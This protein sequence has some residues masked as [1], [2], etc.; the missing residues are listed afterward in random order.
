MLEMKTMR[1]IT[2]KTVAVRWL[3]APAAALMLVACD[4]QPT[5]EQ[6]AKVAKEA[7][8]IQAKAQEAQLTDRWNTLSAEIPQIVDVVTARVEL[9]EKKHEFPEGV[10]AREVK[11]AASTMTE[12]WQQALGAFANSNM[13]EAVAAAQMAKDKGSEVMQTL[14]MTPVG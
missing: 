10:D 8:E 5:P 1:T 3:I 12:S 2:K 6:Q 14:Q 13:P 11:Q 4:R 7:Q 9:L